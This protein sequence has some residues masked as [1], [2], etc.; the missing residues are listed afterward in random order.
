MLIS[1][2]QQTIKSKV[3][4]SNAVKA[5]LKADFH[6][7]FHDFVSI[8]SNTESNLKKKTKLYALFSLTK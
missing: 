8:F 3:Y 4:E 5:E 1:Y 2:V 7:I 6:K